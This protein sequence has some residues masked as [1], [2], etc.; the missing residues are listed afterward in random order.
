MVGIKVIRIHLDEATYPTILKPRGNDFLPVGNE[1]AGVKEQIAYLGYLPIRLIRSHKQKTEGFVKLRIPRPN[2]DEI[3]RG[4]LRVILL[5]EDYII[6]TKLWAASSYVGS[7]SKLPAGGDSPI[8]SLFIDLVKIE[9]DNLPGI[10]VIIF[11]IILFL[12]EGSKRF[13]PW[14]ILL[15]LIFF[16]LSVKFYWWFRFCE[17]GTEFW[18]PEN[19][20]K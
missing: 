8:V 11:G 10:T 19:I 20:K 13:F 15:I 18:K 9:P 3:R 2:F 4:E 6:E 1:I 16:L 12:F 7:L 5:P 17:E 14:G